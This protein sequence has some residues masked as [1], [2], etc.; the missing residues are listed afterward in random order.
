MCG[1][2]RVPA[3]SSGLSYTGTVKM[4]PKDQQSPQN[5][6]GAKITRHSSSKVVVTEWRQL[7][8]TCAQCKLEG[9]GSLISIGPR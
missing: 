8:V 6:R 3:E 4:R 2:T 5:K 1:S 9:Q 7:E